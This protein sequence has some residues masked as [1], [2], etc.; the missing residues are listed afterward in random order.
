MRIVV[1]LEPAS[2]ANAI[3]DAL[4]D[5]GATRIGAISE[6]QPDVLV[7]DFMDADPQP[8]LDRLA[9]VPGVRYAELDQL[10]FSQ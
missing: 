6:S 9:Q 4:R 2:D 5:A 3:G 8:L 10:R 1:G 7:A